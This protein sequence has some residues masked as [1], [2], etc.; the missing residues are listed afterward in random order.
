M[1]KVEYVDAKVRAVKVLDADLKE[2]AKKKGFKDN[3]IVLVKKGKYSSEPPY[4][5]E[6]I[7]CSIVEYQ[8]KNGVVIK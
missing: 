5:L 3:D 1:A 8:K 4:D 7:E 2:L 6:K